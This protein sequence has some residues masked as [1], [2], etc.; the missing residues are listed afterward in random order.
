MVSLQARFDVVKVEQWDDRL[1]ID[2][3]GTVDMAPLR[4]A[5]RLKNKP[6]CD[7]ALSQGGVIGKDVN[8]GSLT[9]QLRFRGKRV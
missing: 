5:R 7:P 4:S 3:Y 2:L 1:Y 6:S 9:I 8:T